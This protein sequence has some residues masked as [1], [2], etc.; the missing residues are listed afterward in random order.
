MRQLTMKSHRGIWFKNAPA[1][2]N[3]WVPGV[4]LRV[5][6]KPEPAQYYREAH[7]ALIRKLIARG[8]VG[9]HWALLPKALL[10]AGTAAP[11][12]G[13]RR[14]G[15]PGTLGVLLVCC[16]WQCS[17]ARP[18]AALKCVY[19]GGMEGGVMSECQMGL[20]DGASG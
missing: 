5:L 15:L 3:Q 10:G 8:L 1:K 14:R 13:R 16:A 2:A 18:V 6:F 9:E 11:L 19:V 4:V 17:D 20:A 12:A 7:W